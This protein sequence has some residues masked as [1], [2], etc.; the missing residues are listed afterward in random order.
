MPNCNAPTDS[1]LPFTNGIKDGPL[2]YPVTVVVDPCRNAKKAVKG[3]E[4]FEA[5]EKAM[6]LRLLAFGFQL[7]KIPIVEGKEIVA[8]MV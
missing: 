5:M 6:G 2:F 3:N 8:E 7:G 1:L 4:G